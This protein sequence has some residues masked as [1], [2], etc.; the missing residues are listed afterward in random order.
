MKTKILFN[1]TSKIIKRK[2]LLSID[3][4][5]KKIIGR[6]KDI[7]ELSFHLS[8][9]FREFPTLPQLIIFGGVGTGKTTIILYVLKE[10][11]KEIKNKNIKLKVVKIKGS[12]S[13]T[14][15]EILKKILMTISPD[16]SISTASSDLHNKIVTSIAEKGISILIF[17]DE[18]HDLKEA[19]MNNVLYT[20][21]RLGQDVA[22]L[23]IKKQ[24]IEKI[25]KGRVGYILVSNDLNI[26]TK[27][28]ENTRSSLTKEII[29]F[30]RYTPQQIIDILQSRIDEGALYE[31]KIGEGVLE[32]ISAA[33]VKEGQDARYALILLSNVAKE[34]EKR[35]LEKINTS[36]VEEIN[37]SLIQNYLKQFIRDLPELHTDILTIIY[38]LHKEKTKINSKTIWEK[39][40][41]ISYLPKRDFSRISQIITTLEKENI[42]YITQSKK[43]KLRNLSIDENLSEIEEVLKERGKID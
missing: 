40:Q 18:V 43:T 7:K 38:Q 41:E 17:I 42:I 10:L 36:L 6:D 35:G 12:E 32:M 8:Y 26:H 30:K 27:L 3:Y 29:T 24:T 2:E 23:D 20:I 22:F 25:D 37:Q 14:K 1:S 21:S 15:Y 13:K 5:P 11:E 19:E 31:N 16:I 34:A 28:K 4:V 9:I 39:Y 33:S